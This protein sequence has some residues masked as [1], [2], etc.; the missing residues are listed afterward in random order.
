MSD[1]QFHSS[2]SFLKDAMKKTQI[3]LA[4]FELLNDTEATLD[5]AREQV[6]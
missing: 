6:K 4:T 2:D 1:F 3:V 5:R